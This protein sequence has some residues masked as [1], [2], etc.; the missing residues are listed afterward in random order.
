MTPDFVKEIKNVNKI[1]QPK[2]R[3]FQSNKSLQKPGINKNPTKSI[4][5]TWHRTVKNNGKDLQVKIN[6]SNDQYPTP[7]PQLPEPQ[8][9]SLKPQVHISDRLA[10]FASEWK[11]RKLSDFIINRNFFDI[12]LHSFSK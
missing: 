6:K 12:P 10:F 1:Q 11:S 8:P 2:F 9:Q 5:K 4:N 3:K 7:Q